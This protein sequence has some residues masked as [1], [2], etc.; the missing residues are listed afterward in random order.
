MSLLASFIS[1]LNSEEKNRL[2]GM[3]ITGKEKILLHTLLVH[4]GSSGKQDLM[5]EL[6]LSSSHFDKISTLLLK[7]AYRHFGGEDELEQLNF[8]SRKFMFHHLFH[9]L[10]QLRGRVANTGYDDEK[11]ERYLRA[12]FDFSINV[13]AKYYEE[14]FV[15]RMADD[16]LKNVKKDKPARELEVKAKMLFARLNLLSQQAPDSVA[17][18]RIE[19]EIRKTELNYKNVR[20]P[21]AKAVLYH[22]RANFYRMMKPDY[23]MRKKFLRKIV[24]LYGGYD[25]MPE[26]EKAIADCHEAEVLFERGEYEAAY[27]AYSTTMPGKIQLLRNQFHHFARWIQ[28]AIILGNYDAAENLLNTLFKMYVDNHHETN[29]VLGALLYAELYLAK[30]EFDPAFRYISMAKSL[31]SIQVYFTYEIRLRLLETIYFAF[32]SDFEFVRRLSL[33]N[34]RYIQLQKLSLKQFKYAHFF[35]LLKDF[36]SLRRNYPNHLS[37]K[38]NSYIKEFNIGYDKILGNLL[39]KL[40]DFNKVG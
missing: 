36:S 26:F 6:Q 16:Y 2:S 29:G 9:E 12:L 32:T 20:D 1:F 37:P 21:H 24:Q 23:R 30:G 33:R 31:N 3:P 18:R 15:S 34:I 38:I 7:K 13:P 39:H 25:K 14:D 4:Q 19:Q 5:E 22:V 11:R 17:I 35:Y 8:L 28:L 40:F 10:R 27:Y